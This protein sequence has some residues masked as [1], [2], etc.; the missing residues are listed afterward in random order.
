MPG[1]RPDAKHPSYVLQLGT[2][3]TSRGEYTCARIA[4][5][6]ATYR[7]VRAS[8]YAAGAGGVVREPNLPGSDSGE[9]LLLRIE[10]DTARLAGA[11]E[12]YHRLFA[13]AHLRQSQLRVTVADLNSALRAAGL[14]TRGGRPFPPTYLLTVTE[15]WQG[16]PEAKVY[17]LWEVMH[18]HAP[19]QVDTLLLAQRFFLHRVVL[20]GQVVD[21]VVEQHL[22]VPLPE[23]TQFGIPSRLYSTGRVYDATH[24]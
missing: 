9:D 23:I 11:G 20:A 8:H 18:E 2:H 1:T 12:R 6:Q 3:F 7:D 16:Q 15:R 19:Q 13:L 24:L 10:T 21:V 14:F 22:H 17:A 4:Q 5:A